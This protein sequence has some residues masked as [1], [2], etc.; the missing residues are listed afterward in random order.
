VR[1]TE[2]CRPL[3][4]SRTSVRIRVQL[5]D[6]GKTQESMP[7]GRI[8]KAVRATGTPALPPLPP[9]YGAASARG[10]R[11]ARGCGG[12][13]SRSLRQTKSRSSPVGLA[14]IAPLSRALRK[15]RP[16]NRLPNRSFRDMDRRFPPPSN[17][18]ICYRCTL[19]GLQRL[20]AINRV[21]AIISVR[22]I[23]P[24]SCSS[25]G[26]DIRHDHLALSRLQLTNSQCQHTR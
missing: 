19:C 23:L 12:R 24:R 22:T 5:R 25:H 1:V 16:R 9:L 20:C 11:R 7:G 17:E 3:R 15:R 18:R 26:N 2:E 14:R 4:P 6:G 21:L 10:G 13:R 8:A